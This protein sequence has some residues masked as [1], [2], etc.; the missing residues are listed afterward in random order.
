MRSMQ[1]NSKNS[2][3]SDTPTAV[4]PN[5]TSERQYTSLR[6]PP[7]TELYPMVPTSVTVPTYPSHVR[8]ERLT[9]LSEIEWDKAEMAYPS[10]YL[11]LERNNDRI[12]V[13]AAAEKGLEYQLRLEEKR[14]QRKLARRQKRILAAKRK[15]KI[16][17]IET[18]AQL[19]SAVTAF[20]NEDRKKN[21]G[22]QIRISVKVIGPY[23][24]QVEESTVEPV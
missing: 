14:R 24:T 18:F 3:S 15:S 11:N 19:V 20:L 16:E 23:G 4:L 21:H 9:H 17:A 6:E 8:G 7:S 2:S 13:F 10:E 22:I 1:E 12:S 5:G